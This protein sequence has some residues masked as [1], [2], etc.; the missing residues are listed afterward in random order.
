MLRLERTNTKEDAAVFIPTTDDRKASMLYHVLPIIVQSRLPMLASLR[1]SISEL[2]TR[3]SHSKSKS[4][5]EMARP[6]TPPPD[7][8][9]GPGSGS[10]TPYRS[11]FEDNGSRR[12]DTCTSP[13]YERTSGI[14]WQYARHGAYGLG[15]FQ[16]Q[17]C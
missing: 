7:Y 14:N 1:R 13:T 16:N 4:L 9:S 15:R 2:H 5:P 10:A 3:S 11:D 12:D 6:A 8:T 17:L